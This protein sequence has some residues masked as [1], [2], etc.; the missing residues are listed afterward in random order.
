[1]SLSRYGRLA[2]FP[3]PRTRI[4]ST[5]GV[6][7]MCIFSLDWVCWR[8]VYLLF[9]QLQQLPSAC[10]PRQ[11]NVTTKKRSSLTCDNMEELVYLHEVC[12]QVWEWETVKKM[13]SE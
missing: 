6:A 7:V 9:Q 11:G 2:L 8:G 3:F 12:P 10:L 1:M 13:R 5:G 4:L